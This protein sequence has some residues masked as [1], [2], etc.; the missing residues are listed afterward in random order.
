[1]GHVEAQGLDDVGV[2][3]VVGCHGLVGVGSEELVGGLQGLHR[4]DALPHVSLGDVRPIRIG[5]EDGSSDL[6]RGVVLEH[7]DD[8]IGHVVHQV[9]GAAAGIQDDVVAV[10][11]VL[12]VHR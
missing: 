1:M 2:V 7:G 8:V 6:I 11:L 9:D 3:F 5:L 10:Q 4:V 12:M